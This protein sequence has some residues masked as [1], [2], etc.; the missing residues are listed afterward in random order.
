MYHGIL[1]NSIMKIRP[2]IPVDIFIMRNLHSMCNT[3]SR[4]GISCK[5]HVHYLIQEV[6]VLL[7][8]VFGTLIHTRTYSPPPR[9][10]CRLL[11]GGG[12]EKT[13]MTKKAMLTIL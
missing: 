12:V 10:C 6:H 1:H 3:G 8:V 7:S 9:N 5:N 4:Y 13:D 11:K 2:Y